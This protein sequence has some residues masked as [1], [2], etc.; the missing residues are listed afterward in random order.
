MCCWCRQDSTKFGDTQTTFDCSSTDEP[1]WHH[2]GSSSARPQRQ[3]VTWAV[4]N[5][6][7]RRTDKTDDGG[8]PRSTTNDSVEWDAT[9]HGSRASW[10]VNTSSIDT[11]Q[12]VSGLSHV[13][14]WTQPHAASSS[15]VIVVSHDWR[16]AWCHDIDDRRRRCLRA[17]EADWLVSK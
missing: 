13:W 1:Q 5:W 14:D 7:W 8:G 11:A 12:L 16:S 2:C 9:G 6:R 17:G 10:V 15:Q 4:C 3:E